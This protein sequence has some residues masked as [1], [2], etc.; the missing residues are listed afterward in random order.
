MPVDT[1]T[2]AWEQMGEAGAALQYPRTVLFGDSGQVYVSD[3][4]ENVIHEYLPDGL[5]RRIHSSSALTYPFLTGVRGDT[6]LVFN[7][8]MRR[9]D[10][11]RNDRVVRNT[12]MPE[13]VAE[14]QRLQYTTASDRHLYYKTVGEDFD[15][16]LV[17]M[18]DAGDILERTPMPGPV[19]RRAGLLELWGD[20]LL[21][22]SAYQPVVDVITADARMDTL[23]LVGFDSPML[24]RTR[25]FILGAIYE[26]PMLSS[27][28]AT[29]GNALFVLNLR[30]GWLR[31]DVFDRTGRIT[32]RL[33]QDA[34]AFSQDFYPIDLDVRVDSSGTYQLAIAFVEPQ[35]KLALYR[36][37]PA[38]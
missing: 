9:I 18:T 27:A 16:Y 36:W 17:K 20:S 30:P 35:P 33:V 4:K 38:E 23:R 28:A 13:E 19:W 31:V 2:L 32:H 14:K 11:L 29:A 15:G 6:L 7:P 1:L 10:F 24:P 21:S 12:T 3:A 8:E 34:P 26:P 22:L 5:L 25:A 37:D